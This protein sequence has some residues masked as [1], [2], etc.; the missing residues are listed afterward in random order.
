MSEIKQEVLDLA[1][2]IQAD[3]TL[4]GTIVK[5]A[6]GL[7]AKLIAPTGVTIEQLEA[8]N[9]RETDIIA[10]SAYAVGQLA[11]P[12]MKKDEALTKVTF[13][14]PT[15]GKDTINV[16]FDRSRQVRAGAPGDKDAEMKTKYGNTTVTVD[17]YAVGPRNP[18]AA[19]KALLS[20]EATTEFGS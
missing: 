17:K 14:L 11:I 3:L 8:V 5:P 2:E 10:A 4:D 15:T 6:E 13:E 1:K 7:Y 18:L 12:A 19:V 16:S 9:A 20:E